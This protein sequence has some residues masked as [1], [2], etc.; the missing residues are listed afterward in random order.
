MEKEPLE[1]YYTPWQLETK[2][3]LSQVKYI[4]FEVWTGKTRIVGNGKNDP[5]VGRQGPGH[6]PVADAHTTHF[7]VYGVAADN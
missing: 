6:L 7:P 3:G 4:Y 1:D 2:G 5:A